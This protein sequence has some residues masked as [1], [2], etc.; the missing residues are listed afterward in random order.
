MSQ[1]TF[2]APRKDGADL[3]APGPIGATT[4]VPVMHAVIVNAVQTNAGEVVA[5]SIETESLILSGAASFANY[6][7]ATLPSGA[8]NGSQV[9][10]TDTVGGPCMA[11]KTPLGWLNYRTNTII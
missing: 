11:Y 7:I 4:P 2:T 6:T 3:S 10:V 5:N 1:I 8:Q 9:Y